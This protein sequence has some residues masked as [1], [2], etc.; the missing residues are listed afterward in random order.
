MKDRGFGDR[1]SWGLYIQS[2]V[3]FFPPHY[4]SH[5]FGKLSINNYLSTPTLLGGR[6]YL[7]HLSQTWDKEIYDKGQNIGVCE[8]Q[9]YSPYHLVYHGPP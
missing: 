2:K 5:S 6:N 3:N 7:Q 9:F 4:P 8:H 1:Q